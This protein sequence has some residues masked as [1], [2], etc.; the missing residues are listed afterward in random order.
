[1]GGGWTFLGHGLFDIG[2]ENDDAGDERRA[3][4]R[5]V[6]RFVQG[7]QSVQSAR[8]PNA[9]GENVPSPVAET[10]KS[11]EEKWV[12]NGAFQN[13]NRRCAQHGL[14]HVGA[15]FLEVGGQIARAEKVCKRNDE[16]GGDQDEGENAVKR[17]K[18]HRN[19]PL[20][21]AQIWRHWSRSGGVDLGPFVDLGLGAFDAFR[22]VPEDLGLEESGRVG[23]DAPLD[24]AGQTKARQHSVRQ[25]KSDSKMG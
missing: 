23:K 21:N 14:P 20:V 13:P 6:S 3:H 25:S 11:V 7:A 2:P 5:R 12:E 19:R 8:V 4:N 10:G 1:V 9:D 22:L 15:E 16:K 18:R 17:R 24:T